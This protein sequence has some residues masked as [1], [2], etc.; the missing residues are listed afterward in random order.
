[1]KTHRPRVLVVED[2]ESA[3]Q[4]LS[5]LLAKAEYEVHEAV[6]GVQAVRKLEA[7]RYDVVITDYQMPRLNGLQLLNLCQ[8]VWP[9]TL[10]VLVSGERANL[11]ALA[12]QHGAFAWLAKPYDAK[13][14]LHVI[15]IALE[16]KAVLRADRVA[17]ET[18]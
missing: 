1:M 18:P 16:R 15:R 9:E 6:D 4:V 3:R 2:D 14:L 13:E 12:S 11:P 17:A 8:I 7:S 5:L 10:L